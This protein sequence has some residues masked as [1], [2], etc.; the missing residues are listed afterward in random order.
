LSDIYQRKCE[1]LSDP[2]PAGIMPPKIRR[3]NVLTQILGLWIRAMIYMYP[4]NVI[5]WV[6]MVI[7]AGAMSVCVGAVFVGARWRYW[8]SSD[9]HIFGQENINDRLGWHHVMM[10]VATWPLILNFLSD[11]W[12]HKP[13]LTRDLDDKL[14]SKLAYSITKILYSFPASAGIFLAF[15]VPAYLLTGIHYPEVADLNSFYTYLGLMLL[16]LLTMQLLCVSVGHM[17]SSRHVAA[18]ISGGIVTCQAMVSHYMIHKDDL[19]PWIG[20]IRYASPQYWM[21]FPIITGELGNVKTFHCTHNPTI[22]DEKT[23]IIKQ[24]GCGLSNGKLALAYF[25]FQS[26]ELDMKILLPPVAITAISLGVLLVLSILFFCV[27][28]QYQGKKREL[29]N[30]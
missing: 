11:L 17:V 16:Y 3:A 2:G 10:S 20:W 22:P 12:R 9:D 24:V 4:F 30:N 13:M 15:T 19:A 21:S 14:Y 25:G 18:L 6:K 27:C 1:P 7:L 29:R 5:N 28:R 26:P 23:G 8:D